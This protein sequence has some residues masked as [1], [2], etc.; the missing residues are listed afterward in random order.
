MSPRP[1]PP[2]RAEALRYWFKLGWISFGG[3]AG[4]IAMMHEELVERRRW[5]SEGRFLHALNYCTVLPGPEAQQLATYI[6]WL[7]HGAR[8]G[9]AAGALFIAPSLLILVALSWIYLN[10]AQAPAVLAVLAAVKPAVVAI[11]LAAAVRLGSRALRHPWAWLVALAA[12]VAVALLKVPFPVVIAAAAV[13]GTVIGRLVPATVAGPVARAAPGSGSGMTV[14]VGTAASSGLDYL[15]DDHDPPPPHARFRLGMALLQGALGLLLG[16]AV[17][18]LIKLLLTGNGA[19][20]LDLAWFHTKAALVGFGGA[21]AVLPYVYAT[22]VDQ[23]HWLSAEQMIDGLA[24]GESTPGPLIMIVAFVG[25]AAGWT[26]QF[27][28]DG[29]PLLS[30]LCGALIATFYTF[31]PSF[32]FILAGAPFIEGTRHKAGLKGP[33]AGITAAVVGVMLSLALFFAGH[34][35]ITPGQRF[36]WIAIAVAVVAL[37]LLTHWRVG[38]LTILGLA[39]AFG[40]LRWW[41]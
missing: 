8:G 17:Y 13:A 26:T 35:F 40:L 39:A 33:L 6:G 38:V 19:A 11:V 21:Y 16:V 31:L 28:G 32:L 30:A 22:A 27:A 20:A 18:E 10:H 1:Q 14:G 34:V 23:F 41:A 7:L 2:S 5:I 36:D 15:V 25:F 24:L 4:Q 9:I 37:V 12:F 29:M 3:P